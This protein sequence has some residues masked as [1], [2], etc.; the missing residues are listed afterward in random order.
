MKLDFP[1]PTGPKNRILICCASV[2]R[3]KPLMYCRSVSL[4]LLR[5]GGGAV[6]F[7]TN[8]TNQ[9]NKQGRNRS[10]T[11]PHWMLLHGSGL[12]HA[13]PMAGGEDNVRSGGLNTT[14]H[15]RT[16]LDTHSGIR[17]RP[18]DQSG[19]FRSTTAKDIKVL[20]LLIPLP[21]RPIAESVLCPQGGAKPQACRQ[22]NGNAEVGAYPN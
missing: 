21:P 3:R 1:A 4:S 15:S 2:S 11:H 14:P 7:A 10:R 19:G 18:I 8:R 22:A 6:T 20:L 17:P 12:D 16:G 5:G 13:N 9:R